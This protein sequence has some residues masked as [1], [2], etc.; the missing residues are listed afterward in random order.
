[1]LLVAL[2]P[3]AGV[4]MARQHITVDFIGGSLPKIVREIIAN[5]IGPLMGLVFCG[6]IVYTSWNEA[7]YAL[8]VKQQTI[9][10]ASIPTFPFKILVPIFA[11]LICLVL[12]VQII[13]YLVVLTGMVK[14]KQA[15]VSE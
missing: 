13:G 10:A 11:G 7:M 3:L 5:L 12:I 6:A 14:S 1:M 2:A 15:E 9:A 4:Q 8:Q